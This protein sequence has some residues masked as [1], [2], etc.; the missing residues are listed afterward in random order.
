MM[1][2]RGVGNASGTRLEELD[3]AMLA[4]CRSGDPVALRAFVVRY[5]G[6]VFALLSRMLG[7]AASLEDLAQETFLKAHRA[8]A[9][10]DLEREARAST[11]LL[12]IATRVALDHIKQRV[13]PSVPIECVEHLAGGESPEQLTLRRRLGLAIEAAAAQLGDEQRAAFVLFT[14]HGFSVEEIALALDCAPA[15]IKTRLFRARL[16]MRELLE[17]EMVEEVSR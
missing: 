5:Q 7:R 2:A 8:F 15:T 4:R 3:G 13:L 10:F 6:A 17:P 14:F 11:W 16:R 12:T 9:R 1:A